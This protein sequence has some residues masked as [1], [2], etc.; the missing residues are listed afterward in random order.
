MS[1]FVF[2]DFAGAVSPAS[3]PGSSRS[4]VGTA[5]PAPFQSRGFSFLFLAKLPDK[6][7]SN[8]GPLLDVQRR[9]QAAVEYLSL[10]VRSQVQASYMKWGL[11]PVAGV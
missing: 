11:S 2:R 6:N 10:D 5:V 7:M 4:G 9:K 1:L 8:L 3:C